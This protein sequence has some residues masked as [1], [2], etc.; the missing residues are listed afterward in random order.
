MTWIKTNTA[1]FIEEEIVAVQYLPNNY[2]RG[3]DELII[4]LR[5]GA[6]LHFVG[7]EAIV[8]WKKLGEKDPEIKS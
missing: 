2:S 1:K 3:T 8:L 5:G 4:S 7:E 6:Q